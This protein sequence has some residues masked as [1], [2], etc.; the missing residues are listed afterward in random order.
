MT[1]NKLKLTRAASIL[2]FGMLIFTISCKKNEKLE[3]SELTISQL[4]SWYDQQSKGQNVNSNIFTAYIPD[5]ETAKTASVDGYNVTE[6]SFRNPTKVVIANGAKTD[7]EKD[8]I[9][10]R[11]DIKLVLFNLS[12]SDMV[13]GAYMMLKSDSPQKIS[14]AH[15][16]DFGSFTGMLSYYNF[17]GKFENGY[18]ISAGKIVKSLTK[19]ALSPNQLLQLKESKNSLGTGSGGKLM[20]YNTNDDCDIQTYD[21]YYESCASIQ[22]MPELGTTC[23]WIYS[24]SLDVI[25]CVPGSAGPGGGGILDGGYTGIGGG[26]GQPSVPAVVPPIKADITIDPLAR[27][28][29]STISSSILG[30]ADQFTKAIGDLMGL[31]NVN[32]SV[33]ITRLASL[34][35]YHVK[36]SEEII[37]D[38]SGVDNLG[39][40]T[41]ITT[42]G[43]TNPRTG[44][45]TLN[46]TTLNNATDLGVAAT[47]IHEMMHSYFI[48]GMR[49]STDAEKFF[50]TDMNNYLYGDDGHPY[51]AYEIAQ[52]AQ[53]AA[54]YVDSMSSL[55]LN[56]AHERGIWQSPDSSIS[57][58]DYCKDIFWK[59]LSNTQPYI[60]APNKA[61]AESNGN[62][63]LNNTS[64]STKKKGC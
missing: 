17:S 23:T 56:Y 52:H 34:S 18:I 15:Y 7:A 64:N 53:M 44:N 3:P 24:Y 46:T 22:G 63:E 55:L 13:T 29:I 61:R 4:K 48:Y 36:I 41:T 54:T 59:N 19:S 35:D 50:F 6:I 58:F 11:T 33:A 32:A 45:I 12:G 5:W 27:P 8:K 38:R 9:L 30:N 51:T 14:E 57:L 43:S 37:P 26:G 25:N 2:F 47:M 10:A 49:Y 62:R 16:K 60:K 40:P 28:C 1:L 21:V 20:L 39:D 31:S 42:N